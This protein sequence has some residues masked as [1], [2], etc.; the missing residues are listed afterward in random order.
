MRISQEY[1]VKA[2]GPLKSVSIYCHSFSIL[3]KDIIP[4]FY[5]H[6]DQ[7]ILEPFHFI[8]ISFV[9]RYFFLFHT[10]FHY[11]LSQ[12]IEYSFLCYTIG[13]CCLFSTIYNSLYL[14][15]QNSQSF[16]PS[17]LPPTI[18]VTTCLFS[19]SIH[20]VTNGWVI[21][22]HIYVPHLLHPLI[23]Q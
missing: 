21:F 8:S 4:R 9:L 14:L 23:C 16:P 6:C 2:S 10:L 15:S 7:C 3:S 11:G 22:H 5:H 13:L 17:F 1:N 18:L 12:H 19:R 20:V